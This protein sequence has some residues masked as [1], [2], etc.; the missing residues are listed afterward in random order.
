MVGLLFSHDAIFVFIEFMP[1]ASCTMYS[2]HTH[3]HT[4]FSLQCQGD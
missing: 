3:T 2:T 1:V 4:E